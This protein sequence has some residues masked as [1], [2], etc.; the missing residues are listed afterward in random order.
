[1]SAPLGQYDVSNVEANGQPDPIPASWYTANI[2]ESEMK[3]T[4]AGDGAYL[5]I[6]EQIVDGPYKGRKIY[7]RLNLQNNNTTAV[8]IA[9]GTLK[10]IYQAVGLQ[11]ADD[12][13]QLHGI[14]HKVKVKVRAANGNYAATN[15]ITAYDP[16]NSAHP[17]ETGAGPAANPNAG[18]V[19]PVGGQPWQQPAST[20]AAPPLPAA[21]APAAPAHVMTAKANGAKY[22]D[23]VAQGW[24]DEQLVANGYMQAPA[25]AAPAAPAAP[26]APQAPAAPAAPS[27]GNGAPPWAR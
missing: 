3:P 11:R 17:V 13:S 4:K 8:E 9:Y 16:A 10:A 7:D 15:E 19:P 6:V 25:A 24:T 26:V 1:M 18:F 14:V 22:E 20:P 27:A 2:V 23:F 21:P 12:S 5:Q